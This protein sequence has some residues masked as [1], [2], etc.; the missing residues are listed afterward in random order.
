MNAPFAMKPST[1]WVFRVLNGRL[2]GAER[3]LHAG[4]QLKVGHAL[5]ND[6]VLRG[7]GTKG[8]SIALDITDDQAR[9]KVLAGEIML[10]GRPMSVDQE[11]ILPPYLPLHIG[12]FAIAIGGDATDRWNEAR[13][14]GL[15]IAS[16]MEPMASPAAEQSGIAQRLASR[17][18]PLADYLP[19]RVIGM[20]ILVVA[21][22]ALIGLASVSPLSN[23]IHSE[24]QNPRAVRAFLATTGFSGLKVTVDNASQ[25]VIVSGL[26]ASN[27]DAARLRGLLADQFPGSLADVTTPEAL[28]AA[29]TDILR[30]NKIDAEA[31][32]GRSGTVKV[33]SEYLPVDRQNELAAMLKADLPAL[34]NVQFQMDGRRGDRDLQYFFSSSGNGLATFVD[35]NPGYIVTQDQTRWFVGSIVPT[36]HKILNIGGGRIVFERQGL[37]EE[38][39]M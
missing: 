11:A 13:S 38:L 9:L 36:G 19:N 2:A 3:P 14:L 37:I 1:T 32:A 5:D 27:R 33:I 23:V 7:K 16:D 30:N 17:L 25:T 22:L 29:T 18:Y 35:G 10:L 31:Q 15:K 6:I 26:V 34:K 28:A 39:M 24:L 8:I 12:E 4:K 21:G 20:W